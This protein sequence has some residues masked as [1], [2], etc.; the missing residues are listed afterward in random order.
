MFKRGISPI[1]ATILL[2]GFVIVLAALI[3]AWL[4]QLVDL[5]IEETEEMFDEFTFVKLKLKDFDND[6]LNEAIRLTLENRETSIPIEEI[7]VLMDIQGDDDRKTVI[8]R[9][10]KPVLPALYTDVFAT[11]VVGCPEYIEVI[12]KVI[13]NGKL[14]TLINSKDTLYHECSGGLPL[15]S[16]LGCNEKFQCIKKSGG[17]GINECLVPCDCTNDCENGGN[18][19]GEPEECTIESAYWSEMPGVNPKWDVSISDVD[20]AYVN[21]QTA[22]CQGKIVTGEIYKCTDETCD[23]TFAGALDT[24]DLTGNTVRSYAWMPGEISKHYTFRTKI[25]DETIDYIL[26]ENVLH[27]APE[28]FIGT[29]SF[30]VTEDQGLDRFSYKLDPKYSNEL[31]RYKEPVI[32]TYNE[33]VSKCPDIDYATISSLVIKEENIIPSQFD[34]FN[35]DLK[36]NQN[37]EI[38]FMA[39]SFAASETRSYTLDYDFLEQPISNYGPKVIDEIEKSYGGID[40]DG[41]RMGI[42]FGYQDAGE[43]CGFIGTKDASTGIIFSSARGYCEQ[44]E[45]PLDYNRL[46]FDATDVTVLENGPIRAKVL[47][48]INTGD[49]KGTLSYYIYNNADIYF[50]ETVTWL[51]DCS[52]KNQLDTCFYLQL[53]ENNNKQQIISAKYGTIPF[54][55]LPSPIEN[56]VSESIPWLWMSTNVDLDKTIGQRFNQR[57]TLAIFDLYPGFDSRL[58]YHNYGPT[59]E[60]DRFS[61]QDNKLATKDI[62]RSLNGWITYNADIDSDLNENKRYQYPLVKTI[63]SNS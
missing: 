26:S 56:I 13:L 11:L 21:V 1:I 15:G 45:H 48:N 10:P 24:F 38:V 29:C 5:K 16:Y 30:T 60:E 44:S 49:K 41:P 35:N 61:L 55:G 42:S 50:E 14:T 4:G 12:P 39:E 43:P 9:D 31:A 62:T 3:M 36:F 19:G 52:S 28:N 6:G 58:V 25:K 8:L 32:L 53:A 33:I 51:K 20:T 47:S 2:V 27:T 37:D 57:V 63:L 59:F 7:T 18:P 46:D 54:W 23:K 40:G 22:N 34:D 17:N